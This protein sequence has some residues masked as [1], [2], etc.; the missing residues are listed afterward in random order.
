MTQAII[1]N[2]AAIS[3]DREGTFAVSASQ[4]RR[5]KYS[6]KGPIQSGATVQMNVV[7]PSVYR[8]IFGAIEAGKLGPYTLQFPTEAVGPRFASTVS[9]RGAGQSGNTIVIDTAP[10]FQESIV[11][12]TIVK[13]ANVRGSYVIVADAQ[14]TSSG[15]SVTLDQPLLESPVDNA[16]VTAGADIEFPMYLIE[17][18]RASQGPTGLVNHD[19]SFVFVEEL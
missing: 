11:A 1:N 5:I 19:G 14:V 3:F 7:Q 9:V 15:V 16:I 4:S 10:G 13:F 18:P 12:G 6:R 2:A 17:R 8:A